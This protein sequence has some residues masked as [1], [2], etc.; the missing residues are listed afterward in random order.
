MCYKLLASN[1]CR[2]YWSPFVVSSME[3]LLENNIIEMTTYNALQA[4]FGYG[5]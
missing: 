5:A 1:T 3:S 2:R 4:K